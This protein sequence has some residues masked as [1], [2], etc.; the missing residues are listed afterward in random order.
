[1]LLRLH[2]PTALSRAW[3]HLDDAQPGPHGPLRVIFVRQ[4]VAQG[5]SDLL[6]CYP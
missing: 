4:G 1:V 6:I 3:D 2:A 5:V